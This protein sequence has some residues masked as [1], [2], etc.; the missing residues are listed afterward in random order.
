MS[1][2]RFLAYFFG[3]VFGFFSIILVLLFT[4]D[5]G[6][7]KPLVE[8]LASDI[9]DRDF[10]IHGPLHLNLGSSIE[11]SAG[12]VRL[13]GTSWSEEPDLV[14]VKSL[15]V[16]VE[17][18]SLLQGPILIEHLYAD[19]V[20]VHLERDAGGNNNWGF[21]EEA[22]PGPR[23]PDQERFRLPLFATD[24]RI[25]DTLLT[26][27]EPE[28]GEP[29]R[30]L[31][32]SV[33]GAIV[34]SDRFKVALAGD[35]NDTALGLQVAASGVENLIALQ[36]VRFDFSGNLGEV[37]LDGN[38]AFADLLD[39][40]QPTGVL[41]LD[42]PNMEYLLRRLQ[43]EPFTSG[44]LNLELEVAPRDE[45]MHVALEG[46]FG[47][48]DLAAQGSFVDLQHL[49]RIDLQFEA[50][51]PDIGRIAG[52]VGLEH[53]PS[54]PFT[55]G[56]ALHRSGADIT[57]DDI[58]VTI[59]ET[60][61]NLEGEFKD[62]PDPNNAHASLRLQGPD[63]GRF[64][65]LLGLP[66]KLDG[67][68][69]LEGKLEPLPGDRGAVVSLEATT[70]G[71]KLAADGN[72]L[73]TPDFVGSDIRINLNGP[74]LTTVTTALDLKNTL[75]APYS[76]DAVIERTVGGAN[77][78][79]G[80]LAL[81]DDAE[82]TMALAA[83]V[84]E[85]V[86]LLGSHIEVRAQ[87]PSLA[88]LT[89][90]AGFEFHGELPIDLTAELTVV[91]A[92]YALE[93][94]WA[95]FGQNRAT[96][97][98]V[99]GVNP[100]VADTDV[101]FSV[102]TPDL[103]ASLT[104]FGID[105]ASLPAI[106][107]NASGTLIAEAGRINMQ[108]ILVRLADTTV[109]AK[110]QLGELPGLE[111]SAMYLDVAG[112]N[113]S[114]LLP[115][116]L[117]RVS[118]ARPFSLTADVRLAQQL[119]LIK[120]ARFEIAG[121]VLTA[122]TRFKLESLFDSGQFSLRGKSRDL[123]PLLPEAADLS[124]R[125]TLP[126]DFVA[127]GL[128]ADNLW[129]VE[130]LELKLAGTNLQAEG[131]LAVPPG[132]GKTDLRLS[133]KVDSM[134]QFSKLAGW[135]LPDETGNIS[136]HLVGRG[137]ALALKI[138]EGRLGHSDVKGNFNMRDA[139]V[140]DITL[141][142]TSKRLN[143]APYL[144]PE[145][146]TNAKIPAQPAPPEDYKRR[147]IPDTPLPMD[148]LKKL[149]AKVDLHVGEINLRAETLTDVVLTGSIQGGALAI[150]EFRLK[151]SRGGILGGSMSLRP[152]VNG[153]M[154][155]SRINGSNLSLGLS[156][157]TVQE[158][159][160]LPRYQFALAL[161]SQGRTVRELAASANGYLRL[162]A[163]EGRV[164]ATPLRFLTNDFLDQ[165]LSTVNPFVVQDPYTHLH[166]GVVLA[167]VEAGQV[168]GKPITIMKTDRLNI[169]ADAEIDLRTEKLKATFNTVP[170]KGLGIS[171]SNLVNPYVAVVGTLGNPQITLDP[172]ATVIE[173]GTAVATLGL[174]ILWKGFKDRFLSS[175]TPCKDALKKADK[176]L[177]R[178]ETKYAN[179]KGN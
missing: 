65:R 34:S 142:L 129:T 109:K 103:R 117:S 115:S 83:T 57:I 60:R 79:N 85:H 5:L 163:G 50:G 144:P 153:A 81:G 116:G 55:A 59:G 165:L 162:V 19:G 4:I 151:A 15:Q 67:P 173:G 54:D 8:Q 105:N 106:D 26:Y 161:G 7:F 148:E 30:L 101:K 73:D 175:T 159:Q 76:V 176:E 139:D 70:N 128:W 158:L 99:V 16:A 78:R 40:R 143:L 123:L 172:E 118:L 71:L 130:Q 147:L 88:A 136:L 72:I 113:L 94:V 6:V 29:L 155:R 37:V 114:Q 141:A 23:P 36:D 61:F 95:E 140:P 24:I 51:G 135:S 174:S 125:D 53:V 32:S 39:P 124:S 10:E 134:Q 13:A 35:F 178:L 47:E 21:Y 38:F 84:T 108:D 56:G 42:G 132:S 77:I 80:R 96:L 1:Y 64:S 92:G 44:P 75:D 179:P 138:L 43:M 157:A 111:G 121:T 146:E 164:K 31:V 74:T 17:F 160:S 33:S 91:D 149:Q 49:E 69:N 126:L 27:T 137:D 58:A 112:R 20:R 156:A 28:R 107:L 168:K 14:S 98:G 166:C 127:K 104:A 68:F 63:I 110:G 145:P 100:L 82:Y 45:R 22:E 46:V 171:L 25:T 122:E 154:L 167:E 86:G 152:D 52:L 66:G 131:R 150:E 93:E 133:S 90:I 177:E 89:P 62:F 3:A 87:G 48:F 9:L 11:I 2:L 120:P 170:Q 12:N 97:T 18:R 169:F 102:M 41:K 119:L